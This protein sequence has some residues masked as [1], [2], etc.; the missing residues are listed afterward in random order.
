MAPSEVLL[1]FQPLM[2]LSPVD[3]I[4]ESCLVLVEFGLCVMIVTIQAS[5]LKLQA[6]GLP[7]LGTSVP[8]EVPKLPSRGLLLYHFWVDSVLE[9]CPFL[10][11][12]GLCDV[13]VTI[14]D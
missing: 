9:S 8:S 14:Q 5:Y 12:F 10:V 2:Y 11:E 7:F 4:L 1:L 6:V 13:I 3:S